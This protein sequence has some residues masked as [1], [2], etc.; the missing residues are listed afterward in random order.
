MAAATGR[1]L[2][3]TTNHLKYRLYAT[4]IALGTVLQITAVNINQYS[5]VKFLTSRL[6]FLKQ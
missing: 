4:H 3:K 1:L 2:K 6:P 5:G